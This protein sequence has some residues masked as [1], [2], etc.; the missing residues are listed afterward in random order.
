ML[1]PLCY[2]PLATAPLLLPLSYRFLATVPQLPPLS[3]QAKRDYKAYV[4][5][6]IL[7]VA[8]RNILGGGFA[9]KLR[10]PYAELSIEVLMED[11][12]PSFGLLHAGVTY[13]GSCASPTPRVRVGVSP[14]ALTLTKPWPNPNPNLNPPQGAP[15]TPRSETSSRACWK[16]SRLRSSRRSA[17]CPPPR[18][19]R[20]PQRFAKG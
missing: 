10:L 13:R 20:E 2:F 3:Y 12:K 18:G 17:L 19:W 6:D 1:L 5:S 16:R 8:S 7:V 11:S 9:L 4:F 14:E 15:P